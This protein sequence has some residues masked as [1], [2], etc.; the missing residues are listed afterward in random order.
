[1][2][3]DWSVIPEEFTDAGDRVW[4]TFA[5]WRAEKRAVYL[6]KRSFGSSS[7]Y[8]ASMISNVS[9]YVRRGEALEAVG[10]RE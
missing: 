4:C 2:R 9:I 8:A 1:M 5:R 7:R 10:L 6:S 3:C